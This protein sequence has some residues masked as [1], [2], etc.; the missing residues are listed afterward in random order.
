MQ[1]EKTHASPEDDAYHYDDKKDKKRSLW[2]DFLSQKSSPCISPVI[3]TTKVLTHI[4]V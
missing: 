4:E 3:L 2:N 1:E